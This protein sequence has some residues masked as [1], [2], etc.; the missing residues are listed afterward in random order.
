MN[1]RRFAGLFVLLFALNTIFSSLAFAQES[2]KP[3]LVALGDSITFGF[4]LE[5]G[6]TH[7]SSQAFPNLI[8]DGQLN[9]INLG[10]PGWTSK[11]LLNALNGKPEFTAALQK[12]D[13]ITLDIGNNDL[14]QAA[15]LSELLKSGTPVVITPQL[16]QKLDSASKQLAQNLQAI[17]SK[18]NEETDAPILLYNLYNPFGES[19]NPFASSLHALGEKIITTVNQQVIL[20]IASKNG[21]L[22][23]DAYSAF[24]GKQSEYILPGDIHP[25]VIGQHVLA[26]LANEVLSS[27]SQETEIQLSSSPSEQTTGPVTIEVSTN[28]EE[29]LDMKWLPGEKTAADFAGA[30]NPIV[31]SKFQVTENGT[32]TV[33]VFDSSEQGTVKTITVNNI[34]P[35][36][37]KPE[38]PVKEN[39]APTPVPVPVT[40][41]TA[42]T[43]AV[44]A[45]AVTASPLKAVPVSASTRQT[46]HTL[47]NTATPMYNYMGVGAGLLFTGLLAIAIQRKRNKQKQAA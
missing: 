5:A 42:P 45:A 47:P 36:A 41:T 22:Y 25:T 12:A 29:V 30:G 21:A 2:E 4:N 17:L 37:N 31:N 20:P 19:T 23:V 3:N 11:D 1:F 32:Y 28:A 14:L 13:L 44:P 46:G 26:D 27:F 38:E 6:N 15:G 16:L 24:N 34:Q 9:T 7:P 43:T 33:Y 39:P 18:I 35:V 8:G 10:F 40:G